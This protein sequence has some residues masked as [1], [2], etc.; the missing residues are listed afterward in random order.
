[1]NIKA[2]LLTGDTR[3]AAEAVADQLGIVQAHSELLPQQ[4]TGFIA[5]QGFYLRKRGRTTI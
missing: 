1:M 2:V 4:K 5:E 3:A